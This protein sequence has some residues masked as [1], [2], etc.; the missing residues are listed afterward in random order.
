MRDK[1]DGP[2]ISGPRLAPARDRRATVG[3]LPRSQVGKVRRALVVDDGSSAVTD[4]YLKLALDRP[5][6]AQRHG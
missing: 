5:A 4:N 3:A 6:H 2:V 1:I